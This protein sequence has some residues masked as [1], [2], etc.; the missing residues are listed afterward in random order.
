MTEAAALRVEIE[1]LTRAITR[2]TKLLNE[3]QTK[4]D[5]LQEELRSIPYPI[6]TLPTEII[7]KICVHS[8]PTTG[9][10]FQTD[11][12][13][14]VHTRISRLW[15]AIAIS[16]PALWTWVRAWMPEKGWKNIFGLLD[17]WFS[18]SGDLPLAVNISGDLGWT[19]ASTA[20]GFFAILQ[21]YSPRIRSLK[22]NMSSEDL[23]RLDTFDFQ[24]DS[25]KTFSFGLLYEITPTF[26]PVFTF[27]HTAAT[28][29][30]VELSSMLPSMFDVPWANVAKFDGAFYTTRESLQ[31]FDLLANAEDMEL[32]MYAAPDDGREESPNPVVYENIRRFC[33]TDQGS[34]NDLSHP[35]ECFTFPQLIT[36]ELKDEIDGDALD[37]FFRRSRCPLQKLVLTSGEV[38]SDVSIDTFTQLPSLLDLTLCSP[39]QTFLGDLLREYAGQAGF[40]PNLECLAITCQF[41]D[42][43]SLDIL[44]DYV[45]LKL[46]QRRESLPDA[47]LPKSLRLVTE[48]TESMRYQFS[49]RRLS[50]YRELRSEGVQVEIV[51]GDFVIF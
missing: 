49:E 10:C 42:Q 19:K 45:G 43:I 27:L 8:L 20:D 38:L 36:L 2:Q 9:F 41:P 14:I 1:E 12:A 40:L 3:M 7:S 25:L 51:G 18:R 17:L 50:V 48:T 33:I 39:S 24:W 44:V 34:P 21:K 11:S 22:L 29:R 6:L 5:L 37:L 32:V 47:K 4:L 16:T 26:T 31:V 13:P 23:L 15:R 30:D 28:L 35:L 46:K